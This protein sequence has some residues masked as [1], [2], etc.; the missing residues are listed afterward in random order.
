[1]KDQIR[2]HPLLSRLLHVDGVLNDVL[3][4]NFF[5]A[6]LFSFERVEVIF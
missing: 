3:L 5:F 6:S 4:K 1:M 2:K